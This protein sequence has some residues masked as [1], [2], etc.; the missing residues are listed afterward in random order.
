LRRKIRLRVIAADEVVDTHDHALV[1]SIRRWCGRPI[2]ILRCWN[3]SMPAV[4]P[5]TVD[6]LVIPRPLRFAVRQVLHEVTSTERVGNI[7]HA[8]FIGELLRRR[9]I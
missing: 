1:L 8:V 6:G 7:S 5:L 2:M 4:A 3:P 9:A